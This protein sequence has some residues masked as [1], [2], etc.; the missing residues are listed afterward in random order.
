MS[1]S[2]S[3]P[4]ELLLDLLGAAEDDRRGGQAVGAQRRRDARAAPGRAPPRSGSRRG[5]TRP[6]PPYSSGTCVFISPTSW[7]LA[8]TSCGPGAVLVVLPGDGA[9]LLLREV[10]RQLAQV[11]LL[12]GQRE[13]DH[14]K[15]LLEKQECAQRRERVPG[16]R[17]MRAIDWSVKDYPRKRSRRTAAAS[18]ATWTVRHN[19]HACRTRSRSC[20]SWC[21]SGPWSPR[22]GRLGA[23][24]GLRADR[25]RRP[26]AQRRRP[27]GRPPSRRRRCAGRRARGRDPPD[28]RGA[29]RAPR[30]A[31]A[32]RPPTSRP[33]S[34]RCCAGRAP[35]ADPAL[36]GRGP[37]PRHRP[38]RAARAGGQGAAGRRGRSRPPAA[39]A[40][41]SARRLPTIRRFL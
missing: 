27:T 34:P 3:M 1:S 16:V 41:L 4:E 32:R 17:A 40:E 37:R 22:S 39:R 35:A 14:L 29:Q 26:V 18:S 20:W 38:Q 6:G 30:R 36:V 12:V 21:S 28:A 5:R 10:V 8:N 25:P 11:L 31:R 2:V 15:V 19:G 13:V 7:A 24:R 33:S 23:A 9:D